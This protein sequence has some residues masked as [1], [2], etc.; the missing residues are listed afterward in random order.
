M[1][2]KKIIFFIGQVTFWILSTGFW[3]DSY[4][5]KDNENWID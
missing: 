5:W 4:V 1:N 2:V 3:D